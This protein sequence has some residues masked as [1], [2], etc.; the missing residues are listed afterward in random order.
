VQGLDIYAIGTV[1]FGVEK[2]LLEHIIQLGEGYPA[3]VE[4]KGIA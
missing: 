2:D 3:K 4:R 1:R